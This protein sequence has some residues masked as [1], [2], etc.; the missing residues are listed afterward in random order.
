MRFNI[1]LV[2]QKIRCKELTVKQYKEILKATWPETPLVNP[3][4][5]TLFEIFAELSNVEFSY[6]YD[7]N[8]IEA[9]LYI[10]ELK[11]QTSGNI[12]MLSV[13][14]KDGKSANL[15]LNLRTVQETIKNTYKSILDECVKTDQLEIKLAFPTIQRLLDSNEDTDNYLL[16]VTKATILSNN[17]SIV[18][19]STNEAEAFINF[20]PLSLVKQI[21]T[22]YG[23]IH[24]KIN[25]INFLSF[26]SV[27]GEQQLPFILTFEYFIWFVKLLF[28]EPLD[29][30]YDNMYYLCNIGHIDLGYL[31]SCTPGEYTYFVKKLEQ[32]LNAQQSNSDSNFDDTVL[33]EDY[34]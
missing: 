18:F 13:S 4:L 26:F 10:I 32:T 8:L 14:D 2:T 1:D 7:L 24:T 33:P 29:V 15:S 9:F 28:A 34:E 6:F 22:T 25:A 16:Y 12:C 3:A 11:M 5:D 21:Q 27:L 23:E 30:L 31:E 20:L 17:V 19:S